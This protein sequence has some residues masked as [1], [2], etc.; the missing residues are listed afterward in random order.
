MDET[1]GQS[2]YP[3]L[4]L[5]FL[6]VRV[7][8]LVRWICDS[9]RFGQSVGARLCAAL[10]ISTFLSIVSCGVLLL[11]GMPVGLAFRFS[12]GTLSM[13]SLLSAVAIVLHSDHHLLV[14][15]ATIE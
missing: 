9:L 2:S 5:Q 1:P 11:F 14:R 13:L 3:R 7:Q 4:R 8:Q 15:R 10:A 6:V 12:I